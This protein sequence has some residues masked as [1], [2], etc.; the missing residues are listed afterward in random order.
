LLTEKGKE[1]IIG[2][3]GH[4]PVLPPGD[5]ASVVLGLSHNLTQW[6]TGA[7]AHGTVAF[8]TASGRK[9]SVAFSV[10][11]ASELHSLLYDDEMPRTL[12]DIQKI[13]KSL[14]EIKGELQRLREVLERPQYSEPTGAHAFMGRARRLLRRAFSRPSED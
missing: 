2:H 10:S 7:T 3:D 9:K 12:Y 11:F 14:D 5:V 4:L 6:T 13:S 8:K 1:A